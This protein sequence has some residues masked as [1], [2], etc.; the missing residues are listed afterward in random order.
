MTLILLLEILL[1]KGEL[2]IVYIKEKEYSENCCKRKEI[3]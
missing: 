1:G 2:V 3:E